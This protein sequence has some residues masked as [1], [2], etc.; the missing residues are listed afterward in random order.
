MLSSWSAESSSGGGNVLPGPGG[1]LQRQS[2][3][4][5]AVKHHLPNGTVLAGLH[6]AE[7]HVGVPHRVLVHDNFETFAT[8]LKTGHVRLSAKIGQNLGSVSSQSD[9]DTRW[10]PNLLS[11]SGD[12]EPGETGWIDAFWNDEDIGGT[13]TANMGDPNTLANTI[14]GDVADIMVNQQAETVCAALTDPTNNDVMT[15]SEW[16]IRAEDGTTGSLPSGACDNAQA[17]R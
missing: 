11:R 3:T 5:S 4:F 8:R 1:D 7:L 13:G 17:Q 16:Y 14:G 12:D 15:A 2:S 10:S 9:Q 6:T